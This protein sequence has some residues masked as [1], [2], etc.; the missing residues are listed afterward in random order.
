MRHTKFIFFTLSF[1]IISISVFS[2][3]FTISGKVLDERNNALSFA[4][5][6]VYNADKSLKNGVI[7]LNDG[8][9]TIENLPPGTYTISISFMGYITHNETVELHQSL[10]LSEIMLQEDAVNLQ[11]V[12]VMG[13]RKLIKNDN[14]KTTLTV[15]DSMLGSMPSATMIMSFVPGVTVQGEAVEVIGKGTPLIFIDGREVKN[16]SQISTLQPERIKSITVDRNPSAQYDARYESVIHI[17]TI[18]TKK[19]EFSA[20]LVHG[21]AMGN[22]YSHTERININHSTGKW[23]NYLSY[24][25]KN[26]Q[27]KEGVEV[28]QNI[29]D[30]NI[31]QKNSYNADLYQKNHLHRITFGS[32]LKLNEKH[33]VD[34]Q[35]LLNKEKGN[36]DVEGTETLSGLLNSHYLVNR[37][38][39]DDGIKHNLNFNYRWEIDTLTTFNLFAD[40]AHIGNKD[41]EFVCNNI[42]NTSEI[43]K[44][45]LNNRS[46]FNTYALRAE[47]QTK[48]F[49]TFD[50]NGGMSFSE[51]K[52][53]IRSIIDNVQQDNTDNHSQL[54]E[55][56]I[57]A[58]STLKKQ[59][60]RVSAEIGLRGEQNRSDYFKNGVSVFG[61]TRIL[62]NFFPSLAFSYRASDN[63]QLNFNYAS[64][65]SR[66][67]FSDLD[68]SINYLS[69]VL[70]EQGN[71][72]LQ[73]QIRHTVSLGGYFWKKLNLSL[74][75]SHNQNAIAYIIEKDKNNPNMLIN[76]S[77]NV[78]K[79]SSIDF[80]AF[81]TISAGRWQS[82]LIGDIS[83]PFLKYPYQG[84]IKTNNI[85][86]FQFVTTNTYMVSPKILLMGNFVAQSR[87]SYLNNVI[88]PTYNLVLA[89]N[90][91]MFNGKMTLTVFGNDILNRSEPNTYSEWGNVSTGQNLRPDSR[92][93]GVS[94]KI[95]VNKFKSIFNQSE[96]NSEILKRIEKE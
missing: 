79:S 76:R 16:Q 78:K 14:G 24:R 85:P 52:S 89:A 25:Y 72:E 80:N 95:N 19:Q 7:T 75:Y 42:Q 29:W 43:E 15:E 33:S 27:G 13:Y 62:T 93:I 40:Y 63:A 69:S 96:S 44:Y 74:G 57:S 49:D 77:V 26:E 64:K 38:G 55:H 1:F 92:E 60:N 67:R 86:N 50:F 51:I 8:S 58:Y 20:Q 2:Q 36:F 53:N 68:P 31:S 83:Y 61:K 73:P 39:A 87:Y 4:N 35:Y 56:T 3:H 82:N 9:F 46:A 32:N 30:D 47:Y 54:T 5:V 70:Y 34:L 17:E 94:V 91:V 6:A 41:V 65:I 90:F 88:S 10:K 37:N 81:Y 11:A 59:I 18:P 28:F 71:P 12:Q 66:P 23:T 84:E 48:L 21:S 45:V 22:R